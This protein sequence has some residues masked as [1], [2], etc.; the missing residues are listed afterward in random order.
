MPWK[1]TSVMDE[2]IRFIAEVLRGEEPMTVPCAR[3]G[4][5]RE[6]GHKWKR[7]YLAL[8]PSGLVERSR[9]PAH[10]GRTTPQARFDA[11]R[12][13][14]ICTVTKEMVGPAGLEPATR[15]L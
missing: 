5:S 2:R 6:T 9:A 8:G 1:A 4:I 13:D 3:F 12:H 11:F 7:R 14:D 10:P 15:P